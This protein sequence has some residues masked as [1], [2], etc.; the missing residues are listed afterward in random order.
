MGNPVHRRFAFNIERPELP[1]LLRWYE[2]I[3]SHRGFVERVAKPVVRSRRVPI[4]SSATGQVA[5]SS[6]P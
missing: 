2:R 1:H 3:H 5:L 6:N 4:G